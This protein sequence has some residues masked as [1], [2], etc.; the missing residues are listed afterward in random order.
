[1]GENLN[2]APNAERTHIGIFGRRNAGKS[3]LINALCGQQLAIVNERPGTTTDP[4]AKAMELLPLGPVLIIDTPGLDDEGEL[5]RLRVE[6]AYQVLNKTDIALLTVDAAAG[7]S[8]ADEALWRELQA[9]K[10]PALLVFNKC[11]TATP[12]NLTALKKKAQELGAAAHCVSA[13][14]GLGIRDLKEA[15]AALRPQEEKR[16]LIGDLIEAGDVVVL[17]TPIDSAAP[18]GRLIL[19]QQQVLRDVLDNGAMALVVQEDKLAAALAELKAPPALVVT[20]SQVFAKVAATVPDSVP[21]TGFS[22][23]FARYKGG[24]EQ[25]VAGVRMLDGLQ[26]GDK[27]LIAE[28]CTHHRQCEDIGTVKLPKWIREHSNCS[29][30]F[31]WSSGTEFP[32]DLSPYKLIVHCGGCMINEKEAA[33][34]YRRA[35]EQGVPMCNY[36]IAIAYMHGILQRATAPLPGI[37]ELLK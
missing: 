9:K 20:D 26:D 11:E 32:R 5:G 35:A 8:P 37:R 33:H 4:V 36:G 31:S 25:A 3:S 24:L 29:P 15:V 7:F 30:D 2:S 6:K 19:P 16:Q 18:K 1:M 17:V 27:V 28:G 22:I 34:R 10:L 12:A 14:T 23:L 13:V 21:L